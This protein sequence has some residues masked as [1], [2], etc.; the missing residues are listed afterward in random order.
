MKSVALPFI[1]MI[2]TFTIVAGTLIPVAIVKTTIDK[3]LLVTYGY[4]KVQHALLTLF[5]SSHAGKSVYQILSE[6]AFVDSLNCD[7]NNDCPTGYTCELK[8]CV[9]KCDSDLNL[10][11]PVG[12]QCVNKRCSTKPLKDRLDKVAGPDYCIKTEPT[13]KKLPTGFSELI[14]DI[15]P[16]S[17]V[18]KTA[19]VSNVIPFTSFIVLPYNK[20]SLIKLIRIGVV[21]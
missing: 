9:I 14:P 8:S 21:G 4:E 6:K 7:I 20:D 10:N 19:C 16:S 17:E 2:G 13:S 1:M 15:P 5:Y 11:C 18:L 3:E 12:Y